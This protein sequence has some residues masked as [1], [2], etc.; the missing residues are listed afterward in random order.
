MTLKS[1][2]PD[3]RKFLSSSLQ[4]R[5]TDSEWSPI[6][7][8]YGMWLLMVVLL[9]FTLWTCGHYLEY[10]AVDSACG[11]VDRPSKLPVQ[12]V[13][14]GI[15]CYQ[16]VTCLYR[17]KSPFRTLYQVRRPSRTHFYQVS[18]STRT[19]IIHTLSGKDTKIYQQG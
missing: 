12:S 3:T 10:H 5:H 1:F 19:G 16:E 2:C 6:E 17:D 9:L 7:T 13:H 4:C 14:F 18:L 11:Q 15:H 8:W